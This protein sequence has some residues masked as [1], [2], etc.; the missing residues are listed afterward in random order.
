MSKEEIRELQDWYE[1]N[2]GTTYQFLNMFGYFFHNDFDD[3]IPNIEDVR[4]V[5]WFDN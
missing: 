4:F 2:V 5:F 1:E 3:E